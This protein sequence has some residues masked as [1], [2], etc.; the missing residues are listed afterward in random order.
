MQP[1][2]CHPHL[3][4]CSSLSLAGHWTM[5]AGTGSQQEQHCRLPAVLHKQI[6]D[7]LW[8]SACLAFCLNWHVIVNSVTD[9]DI[10][11]ICTDASCSANCL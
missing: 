2:G 6:D 8:Q 4:C 10:V 5:L 3:L 11:V 1:A 7:V 9:F